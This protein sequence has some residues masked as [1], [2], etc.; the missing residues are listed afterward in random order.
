MIN[1]NSLKNLQIV[2]D[3]I[4]MSKLIKQ[5]QNDQK[6]F[7]S[8]LQSMFED[9]SRMIEQNINSSMEEIFKSNEQRFEEMKLCIRT[10]QEDVQSI[11][12]ILHMPFRHTSSELDEKAGDEENKNDSSSQ[13]DCVMKRE[14]RVDEMVSS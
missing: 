9:K 13:A 14:I 12:S 3:W 6:D 1:L 4:W 2:K 11:K 8:H 7:P 5:M 10:M